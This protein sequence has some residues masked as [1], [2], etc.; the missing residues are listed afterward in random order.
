MIATLKLPDGYY[1]FTKIVTC[2]VA[3]ILSFAGSQGNPIS[4][5]S[6]L[7]A[8]V[9]VLFNPVIPIHLS[10][11]TWVFLD[12]GTAAAFAAHLILIRCGTPWTVRRF[13]RALVLVMLATFMVFGGALVL[14]CTISLTNALDKQDIELLPWVIGGGLFLVLGCGI[15]IYTLVKSPRARTPADTLEDVGMGVMENSHLF[16]KWAGRAFYRQSPRPLPVPSASSVSE[17]GSGFLSPRDGL[18][19]FVNRFYAKHAPFKMSDVGSRWQ[20]FVEAIDV[21]NFDH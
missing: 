2:G 12:F 1:T 9:A 7:L 21:F 19:I 3:A 17:A 13:F 4:Q 5:W 8:L 15:L 14:R 18:T 20:R 6:V 16:W 10:R 11:P